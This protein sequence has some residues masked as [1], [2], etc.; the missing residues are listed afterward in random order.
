MTACRTGA[1]DL[2][3]A[4]PQSTRDTPLGPVAVVPCVTLLP[5]LPSTRRAMRTQ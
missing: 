4:S 3:V 2:A 1:L 5:I